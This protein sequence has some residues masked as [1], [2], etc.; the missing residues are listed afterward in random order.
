M[1]KFR[2]Y[3]TCLGM[4]L[5]GVITANLFDSGS[6]A[7]VSKSRGCD[8]VTATKCAT[9]RK[10]V[11]REKTPPTSEPSRVTCDGIDIV[12]VGHMKYRI[13]GMATATGSATVRTYEFGF[14]DGYGIE[15]A[16]NGYTYKYKKPGT[17]EVSVVP[18]AI[19]NGAERRIVSTECVKALTVGRGEKTRETVPT[20]T[21][22]DGGV[23]FTAARPNVTEERVAKTKRVVT[24]KVSR[25]KVCELGTQR[26]TTIDET[27][28]DTATHSRRIKDCQPAAVAERKTATSTV[29]R[30]ASRQ[31]CELATND[32]VT[33]V[34]NE[35]DTTRYSEDLGDCRVVAAAALPST[36]P[37]DYAVGAV[38]A[39]VLSYGLFSLY[40]ARRHLLRSSLG[41]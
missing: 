9:S 11:R 20:D 25:I 37:A 7:A 27:D 40:Q 38:G 14:G 8:H 28:Y 21:P 22:G 23:R 34:Q 18:H 6:S 2:L 33:I 3:I 15:V 26:I 5:S 4:L 17:Y 24:E 10:N 12:R 32:V 16:S 13:S 31:V 30:P 19:I 35:I 39:S 29:S 41:Q 1:N 36:G